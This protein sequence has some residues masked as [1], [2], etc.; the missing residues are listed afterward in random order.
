MQYFL[1][2]LPN[3][4]FIDIRENTE[5]QRSDAN[6]G[7]SMPVNDEF[8]FVVRSRAGG[9]SAASMKSALETFSI[10]YLPGD[11]DIDVTLETLEVEE[12][13]KKTV[14][15]KYL[16]ISASDGRH[17]VFNVTRSP[18]HG[19]ID[20]LAS[21]KMDVM[22]SNTSFF[23]SSEI[24]E[25]RL[26]YRHDDS[27]SRRDAF[28]FVATSDSYSVRRPAAAA[29]ASAADFQYLAV[30][31][32]HVILRNDETPSRAVDK[33][34][35]VVE[36]GQKLLTG[37]DLRFVD[38]DIDTRPE[39]IRYNHHSIPNGELVLVD[40]PSQAIFHFTQR[41]LDE[42]RLLFRHMGANFGRIMLWVSD[43]QYFVSTELKVRASPPFVRVANNT[44]LV[45]QRGFS[46]FLSSANLSV[47][48][49]LG[50]CS[51]VLLI[52]MQSRSMIS[53]LWP[54][55]SQ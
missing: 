22:R 35:H 45:V 28:H 47:E 42:E 31:H 7:A 3:C 49:N 55:Q 18:R 11:D 8:R 17:F 19:Q 32:V 43:G 12:G 24:S 51:A 10:H 36:G 2:S 6:E 23:T 29:A 30:F 40:N 33:V 37:D 15:Q 4:G 38:L 53:N 25:E 44:G 20:V 39:D 52:C 14:T 48:T 21:N 41:D 13:A 54:E 5:Y 46:G 26:L 9:E 16:D 27:E 50:S 34:F 1:E